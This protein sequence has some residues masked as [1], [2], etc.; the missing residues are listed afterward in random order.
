MTYAVGNNGAN[1]ERMQNLKTISAVISLWFL[2]CKTVA[3][4]GRYKMFLMSLKMLHRR[5]SRPMPS[6][7]RRYSVHRLGIVPQG[8]PLV[9]IGWPS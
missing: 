8:S 9:F 3:K 5:N 4:S 2:S 1:P 7:S 6:K